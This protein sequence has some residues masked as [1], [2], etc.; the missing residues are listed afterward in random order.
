[1]TFRPLHDHDVVR[2]IEAKERTAE[3]GARQAA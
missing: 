3:A 1:M 2:R